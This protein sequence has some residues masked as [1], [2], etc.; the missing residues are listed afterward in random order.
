MR[1]RRVVRAGREP[2][3][4]P[5][6]PGRIWARGRIGGIPVHQKLPEARI[7]PDIFP[8]RDPEG[9]TGHTRP[10]RAGPRTGAGHTAP[11]RRCP[12]QLCRHRPSPPVD[13]RGH[14]ELMII[15]V[16]RLVRPAYRS[17]GPLIWPA[18]PVKVR[19]ARATLGPLRPRLAIWHRCRH[20]RRARHGYDRP[21]PLR[22]R[23]RARCMDRLCLL[24]R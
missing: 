23:L 7:L 9:G 11:G 8:A 21:V 4:I 1:W 6:F 17:A 2:G 22:R 16:H 3:Q 20:D 24:A 18:V 14:D 19:R 10:L 15:G 5:G 12:C 13:H